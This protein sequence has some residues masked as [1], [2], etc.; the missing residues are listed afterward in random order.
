MSEIPY[1]CPKSSIMRTII[2]LL[3]SLLCYF[4]NAQGEQKNWTLNGYVKNLQSLFILSQQNQALQDNLLH[5]RLNFKWYANDN[6]TLTV[7]A[8]NRLFW[9]D[10]AR[11][12][13][14]KPFINSLDV[15][16]DFFDLSIGTA[17]A[18]GLAAHSMIDRLYWE[19]V[20]DKWEIRL[21]RQR[22]NWGINTIWN[23]NDIFNAYNFTDFD[24]E[25]RPGSDALRVRYY[26]GFASSIELA[27][28]AFDK[29]EDAV[30]ALLWK[31]NKGNYDF[32]I[33]SGIVEEQ[34]ALGG[35]WAGNI[36][37]AS[38]KGEF[39]YFTPI[40][41]SGQ[42]FVATLSSDY[43][44]SNQ[45]YISG[46]F[47]FNSNGSTNSSF[48]D[49]FTTE[50]SAQNLYPY[51][52]TLF[53]QGLYPV[54]PLVNA[55]LSLLYSPSETNALFLNPT[56]TYSIKENWDMDFVGQLIFAKTT[57]YNSPVQVLFLRTK[58]S[59]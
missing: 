29:Q 2:I 42:A 31:F 51:K 32:Q 4:S 49:L 1:F 13:G 7:E 21:G 20:K 3:F 8:R 55:G 34:L 54:S 24:Y 35:G 30:A 44:F 45:L 52:Y 23:P 48:L 40:D 26:T 50:L 58:W 59:F 41:S 25:E 33:L 17:N 22:I 18:Q 6:W 37:N 53:V 14:G 57:S 10:Q 11:L 47:L 38:F 5:N 19:Y 43:S 46:G 27:V 56:L 16:N 39:T 9:G 15:A 36:G 12:S 28:K